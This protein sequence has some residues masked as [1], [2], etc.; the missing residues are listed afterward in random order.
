M[1]PHP[2]LLSHLQRAE[3]HVE[4]ARQSWDVTDIARCAECVEHLRQAAGEIQ[5]AQ[6]FTNEATLQPPV[7]A[8]KAKDRLQRLH[9]SVNRLGRLVDSAIAFHRRLAIDT[10]MD[11]AMS[12]RGNG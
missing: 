4:S 5:A 6:Q 10:G 3:E 12:S 2:H 9:G 7:L 11:E 8:A 1:T